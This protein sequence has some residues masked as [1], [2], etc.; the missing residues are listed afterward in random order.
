[1]TDSGHGSNSCS[2]DKE[3]FDD[4]SKICD[5]GDVIGLASAKLEAS[6]SLLDC[7]FIT[8]SSN[9]ND[10][11][12]VS[13]ATSSVL[14]RLSEKI[15]GRVS[16][17]N[18]NPTDGNFLS[19]MQSLNEPTAAS[20]SNLPLPPLHISPA[21]KRSDRTKSI[22]TRM[23]T[24]EGNNFKREVANIDLLSPREVKKLVKSSCN[25]HRLD[26]I[27]DR[28]ENL[29]EEESQH[30]RELAAKIAAR[31]R[32]RRLG[33][34]KSKEERALL[35]KGLIILIEKIVISIA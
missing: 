25:N 19:P 3:E 29:S 10:L 31:E 34:T 18:A 14:K 13:S 26:P 23:R 5:V 16:K 6:L 12:S 7:G 22:E 32:H 11:E 1:M 20:F 35:I 33:C 27:L 21:V 4:V 30:R 24:F 15:S 28:Y 8:E 17:F 9:N 2:N